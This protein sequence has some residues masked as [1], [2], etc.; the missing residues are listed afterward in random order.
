MPFNLPPHSIYNCLIMADQMS[1][2]ILGKED[3][4]VM[5][6][7]FSF[8]LCHVDAYSKDK[9]T[10]FER[11]DIATKFIEK[12][13]KVKRKRSNFPIVLNQIQLLIISFSIQLSLCL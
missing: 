12:L 3:K 8:V 13:M 7:I 5:V 10:T 2:I 9:Q 1:W 4:K 11:T 6:K